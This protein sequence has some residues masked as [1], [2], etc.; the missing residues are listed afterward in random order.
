MSASIVSGGA[1]RSAESAERPLSNLVAQGWEVGEY[2]ASKGG[3][4]MMEHCFHLHRQREHKILTVRKKLM[5]RGFVAEEL[6][7]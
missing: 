2:C 7:V 5:G 1:E 4:G 6:D 3:D